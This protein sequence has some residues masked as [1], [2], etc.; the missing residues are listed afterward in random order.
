MR[1]PPSLC[2]HFKFPLQLTPQP[3]LP[4]LLLLQLTPQS[5]ILCFTPVTYFAKAFSSCSR[6]TSFSAP[7]PA[8][9]PA[10]TPA[11]A[12]TLS[13]R[14]RSRHVPVLPPKPPDWRLRLPLQLFL[15]TRRLTRCRI[16]QWT[17]SHSWGQTTSALSLEVGVIE[18]SL[19]N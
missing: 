12:T 4:F 6:L 17:S 8:R 19:H 18:K 7:T 9:T 3:L 2:Y 14:S 5:L 16:S 11:S 15:G 10:Y 1:L 13:S